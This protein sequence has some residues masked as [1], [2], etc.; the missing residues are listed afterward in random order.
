MA[1][2]LFNEAEVEEGQEENGMHDGADA[3]DLGRLDKI[4]VQERHRNAGYLKPVAK[5]HLFFDA[6]G[7]K[8][9]LFVEHGELAQLRLELAAAKNTT[10]SIIS[11]R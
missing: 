10:H 11:L 4:R 7:F 9:A 8:R 3:A 6:S 5:E 2:P 1:F